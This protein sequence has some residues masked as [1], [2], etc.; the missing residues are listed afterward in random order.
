MD[1]LSELIE[2]H[3]GRGNLD[4]RCQWSGHWSLIHEAEAPGTVRYH[5]VVDG[6][7]YVEI[8]GQPPFVAGTGDV[9]MLP[10]GDRHTL[11]ANAKDEGAAPP[12][13]RLRPH[14]LVQWRKSDDESTAALDLFCGLIDFGEGAT[15]LLRALPRVL[16]LPAGEGPCIQAA[17]SVVALMRYEIQNPSDGSRALMG[18]LSQ[19]LFTLTLRYWWRTDSHLQGIIGLLREPR[20][21]PA[22]VTM[23]TRYMDDVTVPALADACHM[24][25]ASFI[26][27][28]EKTTQDTPA[29]MLTRMRMDAAAVRLSRT[30]ENVGQI[31]A[32]VGFQSDSAFIRAFE[33]EK[34][35]SPSA[36]R[37]QLSGND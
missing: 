30:K 36:Y 1:I 5:V 6:E 17:R 35:Q 18:T 7:L 13:Y 33:R 37:R 4:A 8:A 20:L 29:A 15:V 12:A 34:G 25:R 16:H 3:P 11:A 28:F 26:R 10:G 32:S 19:S 2:A 23:L 27:L 31:A 21:R 9:I 22:A 24:S 14:P